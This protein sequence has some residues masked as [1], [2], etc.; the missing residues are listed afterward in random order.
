MVDGRKRPSMGKTRRGGMQWAR[1][2]WTLDRSCPLDMAD[3]LPLR[4][5]RLHLGCMYQL[6]MLLWFHHCTTLPVGT[7]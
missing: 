4:M 2:S 7:H 3:I 6:D 5:M 1:S